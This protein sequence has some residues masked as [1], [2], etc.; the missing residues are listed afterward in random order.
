MIAFRRTLV[1]ALVVVVLVGFGAPGLAADNSSSAI[2]ATEETQEP[3]ATTTTVVEYTGPGAFIPVEAPAPDTTEPSW[4]YKF[5]IPGT[6]VL[7]AVMV[8]ALVIGYFVKVV[9]TRYTVVE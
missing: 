8:L 6:L 7:I 9:R 2:L 4:T 3:A 1:S 5:L